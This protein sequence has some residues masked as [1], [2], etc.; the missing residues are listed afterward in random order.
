MLSID[1]T[2]GTS[3]A[4]RRAGE[5]VAQVRHDSGMKHAELI[6]D[7]I[8]Q[9]LAEAQVEPGQVTS[10]A[11]GRGPALFTGLRVGIAAAM[12]FSEAT[13]AR[14]FGVVSHDALALELLTQNPALIDRP[15]LVTTDARRGEVY[16]ALYRGLDRHGI[17]VLLAGHGVGKHEAVLAELAA[18]EDLVERSG[19]A[20][21]PWVGLLTELQLAAGVASHDVSAL[22]LRAPDATPPDPSKSFAKALG[23]QFGKRVTK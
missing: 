15:L 4:L 8:V 23:D 22:Y 5:L 6:G 19:G 20:S 7:A 16:W 1:T 9:V 3:V 21:A 12:L 11:V 14:L 10:V 13:E 2:A 18:Y 17:P